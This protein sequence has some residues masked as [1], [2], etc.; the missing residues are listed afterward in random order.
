MRIALSVSEKEKASGVKSPYFQALLA[1][2]AEENEIQ[3]VSASDAPAHT[4]KITMASCSPVGKMW[5]RPLR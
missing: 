4:P 1:A 3:L 5:T 2:G